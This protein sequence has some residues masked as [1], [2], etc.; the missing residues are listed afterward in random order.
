ML[1]IL[2]HAEALVLGDLQP[3]LTQHLAGEILIAANMCGGFRVRREAQSLRKQRGSRPRTVAE[4]DYTMYRVAGGV[5]HQ[6]GGT[7]LR[8]FKAQRNGPIPPG[9][10][11]HVAAIAP[12]HNGDTQLLGRFNERA[13]LVTGGRAQQQK[14]FPGM[15]GHGQ[16]QSHSGTGKGVV[17]ELEG[18]AA[19]NFATFPQTQTL[20]RSI[21]KDWRSLH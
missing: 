20:A 1:G 17:K 19:L 18:P 5:F 3:R 4:R 9:I 7:G 14:T 6:L 21:I 16:I 10:I 12:K 15:G 13:R 8:I 11:E 2:F